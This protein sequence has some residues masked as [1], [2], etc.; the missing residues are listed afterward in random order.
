MLSTKRLDVTIVVACRNEMRDIRSFLE[1]LLAQDTGGLAWEAIIA[2]GLSTDGT[3]EFLEDYCSHHT[4]VRVIENPSRFVSS[5]L[6][7]AIRAARGRIIIRMDAHTWY[8]PDYVRLCVATLRRTGAANVGGPARTR[9]QSSRE[10]AFSAAYHSP[11]STGGARFHNERYEGWVDTVTYGCWY[12]TTLDEL[13]LFDEML[14][15]NQDDELNLR[16]VR[17]GGRIW[18]N[19]K[20]VSRYSPR[21]TIADL[22]QQ[23]FQYGFWKVAVIKKHRLPAS[24]RH[25]VPIAFI[26]INIVLLAAALF[27][28]L[29]GAPAQAG[30]FVAFW[31]LVAATYVT[32][33]LLVSVLTAR[34]AGWDTLR[35]LPVIFA[36]YHVSY[37]LGFLSGLR[38]Y[39]P[40]PARSAPGESVFTRITR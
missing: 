18:Q 38:W 4:H 35:Y 23:Y 10:R 28:L 36:T 34:R 8:A 27:A 32:G 29:F 2:D 9:A 21:Y 39:L 26:L 13:G 20:I 16:L 7:A 5:G 24:V 12:K 37:G 19:P 3:R 40:Q 31:L 1:S 14:V 15:R 30:N 17:S 33:I 6:N 11:F 22:F 25:L